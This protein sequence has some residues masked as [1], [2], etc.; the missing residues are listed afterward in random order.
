MRRRTTFAT[1]SVAALTFGCVALLYSRPSFNGTTQGCGGSGCHTRQAG[2]LTATP[3][4]NLQVQ[5][6][7]TTTSRVAGELVNGSGTVV[8]VIDQTTS[9]PFTLT[10]PSVGSYV[11][12]AG[13]DSPNRRW[14]SVRVNITLTGAEEPRSRPSDYSLSQNYPNPFNPSTSFELRVPSFGLVSL[15]VF[16]VRGKE[17]ATL[18]NGSMTAGEHRIVF[19]ATGFAS[20]IYFYRLE[21]RGFSQTR[22]MVV[23]K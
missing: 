11:V 10:A 14:D 16:D 5:I 13:Y 3:I 19:D 4:G 15:K 20:G 12:N 1:L 7:L 18:V 9:N 17:V 22:K 23:T 21:T 6:A 8:A 2:I